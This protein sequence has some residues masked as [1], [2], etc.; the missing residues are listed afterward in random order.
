M[1]KV[2]GE[3]SWGKALNFSTIEKKT[4]G[5]VTGING[6]LFITLHIMKKVSLL[7]KIETVIGKLFPMI[8]KNATIFQKKR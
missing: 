4:R 8:G 5:K 7:F 3:E 1:G 6:Y 2:A